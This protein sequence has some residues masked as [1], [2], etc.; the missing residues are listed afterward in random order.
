VW[1]LEKQYSVGRVHSFACKRFTNDVTVIGA[2]KCCWFRILLLPNYRFVKHL[3]KCLCYFTLIETN[4]GLQR[5]DYIYTNLGFGYVWIV[6]GVGNISLF[7]VYF[8]RL[9]DM[10]GQN[11]SSKCQD[12]ANFI[13]TIHVNKI[14]VLNHF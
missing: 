12:S 14:L 6:Q 11:W 4:T 13:F 10:D 9:T 1:G 8:Q 5:L 2:V 3:S 7:F